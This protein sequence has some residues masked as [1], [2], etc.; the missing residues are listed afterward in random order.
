MKRFLLVVGTLAWG[1]WFG[2]MIALFLFVMRLF[3]TNRAIAVDAA[4]VLFRSFAIYQIIVGMIT[5]SAATLLAIQTRK[6]SLAISAGLMLISLA[7]S[8]VL[9]MWTDEMMRLNRS[10]VSDVAR[11]QT[12]HHNT[13]NLYTASAILLFIAGIMTTIVVAPALHRKADETEP[14][15]DFQGAIASR[16]PMS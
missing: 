14:A 8:L 3:I 15:R 1:L 6:K 4:P 10:L 2:G 9:K 13:T 7:L 11:F 12:L 16:S 5:C